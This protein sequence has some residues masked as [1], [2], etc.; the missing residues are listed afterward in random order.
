MFTFRVTHRNTQFVSS[1][2]NKRDEC[3]SFLIKHFAKLIFLKF[4]SSIVYITVYKQAFTTIGW[5]VHRITRTSVLGHIHKTNKMA[6]YS[7]ALLEV[8]NSR[9]PLRET[10][11]HVMCHMQQSLKKLNCSAFTQILFK[12]DLPK[13]CITGFMEWKWKKNA[14]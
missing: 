7:M 1:R 11:D 12:S 2:S 8:Q 5:T 13:S 10:A 14:T 4:E 9:I 6:T 3:I